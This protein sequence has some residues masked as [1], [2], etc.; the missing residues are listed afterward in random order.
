M[1][2]SV[3]MGF[4]AGTAE[5]SV[6]GFLD[7][8]QEVC[9]FKIVSSSSPLLYRVSAQGVHRSFCKYSGF[10]IELFE[11]FADAQ[12]LIAENRVFLFGSKIV[13]A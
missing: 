2:H 6:Q 9:M 7:A 5:I 13:A 8:T 11:T 12:A 3:R 10:Q 4:Y 1:P